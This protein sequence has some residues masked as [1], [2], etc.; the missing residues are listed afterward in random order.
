M[1][2]NIQFVIYLTAITL[3]LFIG[4]LRHKQI[5]YPS[6][7]LVLLLAVTLISETTSIYVGW[8]YNNN[9]PVFHIFSPIELFIISIYFNRSI[10]Y[11]SKHNIG[12]YIGLTGLFLSTLNTVFIQD[13]KTLNSYFLLF[14]GF[15]I[16]FMSLFSYRQMFEDI[17][18]NVMHNPHFWYSSIFLFI[19]GTTYSSW[20]LYSFIGVRMIEIMPFLNTLITL[21]STTAYVSMG[22]LF[23]LLPQKTQNVR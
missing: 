19:S 10:D 2:T 3:S 16:I 8:K 7:V 22:I 15:C 23:L 21:I 14:E 17:E 12:I 20:A 13:I 11:F 4:L 18:M 6:K 5:D 1:D 9:M